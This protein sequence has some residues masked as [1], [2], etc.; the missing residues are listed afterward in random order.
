M[1]CA[2]VWR[3]FSWA[4]SCI[5]FLEKP[6]Q[7]PLGQTWGFFLLLPKVKVFSSSSLSFRSI[8]PSLI[9]SSLKLLWWAQP[10]CW[11]ICS[12]PFWSVAPHLKS[13]FPVYPRCVLDH[14]TQNP[15]WNIIHTAIHST[16]QFSFAQFPV[17]SWEDQVEYYLC[18][19]SL[20][21][22][23]KGQR[24]YFNVL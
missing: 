2:W 20:Q 3:H 24:V 1:M 15:E 12:C 23:P 6:S 16:G 11:S 19:W 22:L 8:S 9:K 5:T 4:V 10:A 13:T 7:I 21:H 17:F 18:S 14:G